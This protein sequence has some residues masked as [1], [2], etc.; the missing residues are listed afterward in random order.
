MLIN[1]WTD[2]TFAR[3]ILVKQAAHVIR[4]AILKI[5][6]ANYD[7]TGTFTCKCYI[8]SAKAADKA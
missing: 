8:D 4:N 5:P 7:Q 6:I 2:D 1:E 3:Y